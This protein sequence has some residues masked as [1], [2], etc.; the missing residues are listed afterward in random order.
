LGEESPILI[1]FAPA[2]RLLGR[3]LFRPPLSQHIQK[4]QGRFGKGFFLL[5]RECGSWKRLPGLFMLRG[6]PMTRC[7]SR[8]DPGGAKE[9]GQMFHRMATAAQSMTFSPS[10]QKSSSSMGRL[11]AELHGLRSARVMPRSPVYRE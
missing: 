6:K 5:D 9:S 11:K 10:D 7:R 2:Q 8:R 4:F 1:G 3:G